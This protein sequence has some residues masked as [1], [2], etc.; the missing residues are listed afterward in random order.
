MR[1]IELTIFWQ[2]DKDGR[3]VDRIAAHYYCRRCE[4]QRSDSNVAAI[5]SAAEA[6]SCGAFK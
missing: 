6:H 1:G 3:K 2:R 4:T 5:E